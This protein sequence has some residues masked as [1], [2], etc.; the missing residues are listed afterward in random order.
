MVSVNVSAMQLLQNGFGEMVQGILAE[1]GL[2]GN[3]LKLELTE[4]MLIEHTVQ[5]AETLDGLRALGIDVM[6]DD[7]GTGFSSLSYLAHLPMDALKVD[8]SFISGKHQ[9]AE[10]IE[11]VRCIVAMAKAMG[12]RTIAEGVETA[13]QA[14]WVKEMSCDYAQGYFYSKPVSASAAMELAEKCVDAE[15]GSE[16]RDLTNAP[17][18]EWQIST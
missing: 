5:L 1:T 17:N 16:K 10:S 11:I 15:S 7:F 14:T 12:I 18:A 4:S 9:T 8:R 6:I 2:P 13:E 3:R